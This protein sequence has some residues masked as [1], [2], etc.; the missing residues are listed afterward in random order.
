M[1]ELI[2]LLVF[3]GLYLLAVRFG[4]DS[5]EGS[6]SKEQELAS[7]GVTWDELPDAS[8]WHAGAAQPRHINGAPTLGASAG[9]APGSTQQLE[10]APLRNRL[11]A[12]LLGA[13]D[14]I[15]PLYRPETVDGEAM[16]ILVRGRGA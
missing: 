3:V 10:R 9:Q 12:L 8:A 15:D 7:Y 11:A 13:A 16:R 5:R 14:R 6:Y 2:A 1:S 4:Y